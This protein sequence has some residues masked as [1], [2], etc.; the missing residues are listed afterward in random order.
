V[1]V[2]SRIFFCSVVHCVVR[3]VAVCCRVIASSEGVNLQRVQDPNLVKE[4]GG[5][6][7]RERLTG[8]SMDTKM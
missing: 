4:R 2:R 5:E 8:E 3:C 6:R 7:E 1:V